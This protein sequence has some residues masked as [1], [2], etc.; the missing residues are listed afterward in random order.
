MMDGQSPTP[1]AITIVRLAFLPSERAKVGNS[2]EWFKVL[3]A[4][5]AAPNWRYTAKGDEVSGEGGDDD[6]DDDDDGCRV[7]LFVGWRDNAGPPPAAL[8]R[9]R[10]LAPLLPLLARRPRIS[11]LRHAAE[12]ALAPQLMTTTFRGRL[13]AWT[14]EV[15]TVG[16]PA[17][18]VGARVRAIHAALAEFWERRERTRFDHETHDDNWDGVLLAPYE[19]YGDG[20]DDEGGGGGGGGGGLTP[21]YYAASQ[22]SLNVLDLLRARGAD[23][24]TRDRKGR[25]LLVAALTPCRRG[26]A[27]SCAAANKAQD[28]SGCPRHSEEATYAMAQMLLSLEAA[29]TS[30]GTSTT[31]A[32]ASAASAATLTNTFLR[33]ADARGST[34]LMRAAAA[35]LA[36]V[37]GLLLDR[38]AD[39]TARDKAGRTAV[40]YATRHGHTRVAALL[41]EAAAV[42]AKSSTA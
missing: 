8:L 38:G 28:G 21:A 20:D 15:L 36:S 35:G 34:A 31:V 24:R 6:R 23:M 32:A 33:S 27:S 37:V 25:T 40:H 22:R 1:H 2:A 18:L 17:G 16:G 41:M 30:T 14:C 10:L 29:G 3:R 12:G 9:D 5:A 11:A 39:V 13:R 7:V 42:A 4:I 19:D 26:T